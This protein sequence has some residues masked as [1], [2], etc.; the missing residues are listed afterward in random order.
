MPVYEYTCPTCEIDYVE[1]RPYEE[2]DTA[3]KCDACLGDTTR[4]WR[5][6]PGQMGTALPDG[7][8]RK[9][10]AELKEAAKLENTAFNSRPKDRP[11]IMK[12]VQKLRSAPKK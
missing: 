8:K 4:A 12:E 11:A 3:G 7:V 1:F 2:R 10:F 6:A 5:T 9:G